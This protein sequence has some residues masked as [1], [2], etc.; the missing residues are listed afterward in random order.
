MS[1]WIRRSRGFVAGA[2]ALALLLA[3]QLLIT[4]AIASRMEGTNLLF[5]AAEGQVLCLEGHS[6]GDGSQPSHLVHKNVCDACAFAA[7]AGTVASPQ[8]VRLPGLAFH[9][10]AMPLPRALLPTPARHEPRSTRGPPL[11][12]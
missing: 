7:Q 8:Q 3:L 2:V 4:S 11:N 5:G 6:E 10:A 12:A 9:A 1:R